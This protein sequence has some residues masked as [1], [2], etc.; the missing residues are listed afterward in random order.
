MHLMEQIQEPSDGVVDAALCVN[1]ENGHSIS[2]KTRQAVHE[3]STFGMP[4]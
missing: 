4:F 2:R 1:G 3:D